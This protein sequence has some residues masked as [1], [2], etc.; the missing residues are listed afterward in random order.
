M[1]K[2]V[3]GGN[4]SALAL[5]T[6]GEVFRLEDGRLPRMLDILDLLVITPE[7]PQEIRMT[8]SRPANFTLLQSLKQGSSSPGAMVPR[9]A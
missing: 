5:T 6:Q 1:V 9:A 4:R 7:N 3:S 8:Q 2:E